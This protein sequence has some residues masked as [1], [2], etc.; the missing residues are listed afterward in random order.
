M[1]FSGACYETILDIERLICIEEYRLKA[2][3]IKLKYMQT[4]RNKDGIAET[5]S[6]LNLTN[7]Y[8]NELQKLEEDMLDKIDIFNRSLNDVEMEIFT[9]KFVKN[10]DND[11]IIRELYLADTSFYRYCKSIKAKMEESEYGKAI[12]ET[13]KK[14]SD[15]VN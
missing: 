11:E 7:D 13:L 8:V 4:T 10:Q 5:Q 14:D 6:L 3:R 2:Y 1:T 15:E 12:L 9:R